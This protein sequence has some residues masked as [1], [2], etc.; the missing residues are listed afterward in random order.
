MD[1]EKPEFSTVH[2]SGKMFL[3]EQPELLT[4]EEHGDLGFTPPERP[5][6]HLRSVRAIP[7]TMVEFGSAQ[8]HYPIIFASLE[9]PVPLAVVSILDSGN[10][11]VGDDGRWDEVC[12]LPSYIRCHPFTV[13]G[14][15]E[16]KLAVV[17]DRSAP[18]VTENPQFP[19]FVGGKPSEQ[20]DQL[21]NFC[22]QYE[23]ERR[24][25][26]QFCE[27]L[28]QLDLL[29][30]YR[31]T[32]K[33]SDNEEAIPLAD[34]VSINVEKLNELPESTVHKLFKTGQLVQIFMQIYS[35]ENF[36]HLMAR[37]EVAK[38]SG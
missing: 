11:F 15:N 35:I 17:I 24:K 32:H 6:D 3:Y 12:Y 4:Q 34:Y 23:I 1:P 10:L 8:R 13:T 2:V 27:H 38:R 33:P 37:H 30:S 28:K 26:L 21:M 18:S 9:N 22:A 7:L 31:S 20:T 19:F 14:Q 25:T 16:E 5:H 36:R 29:A